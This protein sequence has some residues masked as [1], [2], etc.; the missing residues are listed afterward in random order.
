MSMHSRPD[1]SSYPHAVARY[2]TNVPEGDLIR[3]L[4]EQLDHTIQQLSSISASQEQFR[5]AEGKWSLREVVGHIIDFER[6]ISYRALRFSRG[7]Q[8]N[9]FGFE[10]NDYV[11]E[12]RYSSASLASLIEELKAVRTSSIHLL[13]RFTQQD[14]DKTGK[15]EGNEISVQ[16]LAYTLC[17]HWLHHL[18]IILSRYLT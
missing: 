4:Q 18:Q 15:V 8:K 5:Y 1:P 13:S 2:I 16:A 3:L 7:D 14:W 9:L 17:G 10:E 11:R 12:S 6:I